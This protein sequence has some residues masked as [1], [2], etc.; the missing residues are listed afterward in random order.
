MKKKKKEKKNLKPG[1]RKGGVVISDRQRT[2]VTDP[3]HLSFK[4]IMYNVQK[5]EVIL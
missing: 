4:I 3:A 5:G 1:R 2:R